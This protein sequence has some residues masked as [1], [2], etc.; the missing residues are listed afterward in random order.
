NRHAN[1]SPGAVEANSCPAPSGRRTRL[2]LVFSPLHRR[3]RGILILSISPSAVKILQHPF[4]K[5]QIFWFIHIKPN[6]SLAHGDGSGI[7]AEA[8]GPFL[9]FRDG[10]GAEQKGKNK[11]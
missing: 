2:H 1:S 6:L 4:D 8:F 9:D 7:K 5:L 10:E 11:G 3:W